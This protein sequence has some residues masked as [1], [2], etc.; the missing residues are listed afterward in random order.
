MQ[1]PQH[2]GRAVARDGARAVQ[3]RR[4]HGAGE[5]GTAEN[6]LAER[7]AAVAEALVALDDRSFEQELAKKAGADAGGAGK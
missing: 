5:K 2:R 4:R 1:V 6:D 3:P 7:K